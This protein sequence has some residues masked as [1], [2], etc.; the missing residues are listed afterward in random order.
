M[1]VCVCNDCVRVR[2]SVYLCLC[3]VNVES[4]K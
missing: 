2:L 4:L 3:M 1:W